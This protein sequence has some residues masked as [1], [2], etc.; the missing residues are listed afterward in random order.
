VGGA[1]SGLSPSRGSAVILREALKMRDAEGFAP[2]QLQ[3]RRIMRRPSIAP[4]LLITAALAA[5]AAY[6]VPRGLE[7]QRTLAIA[8]DPAQLASRALDGKFDAAVATHDV[9]EALAAKDSDLA[10]SY[11]ELADA[12]HVA[13]DPALKQKVDAAVKQAASV[14]QATKSFAYGFVE[15][16]PRDAASLAGTTLGDLFVFGDIRDAVRE[17]SRLAMGEKAD[18]MILGLA[19]VGLAITAGTYVTLGAEAP[20]R[21]GLTLAKAARKTGRLSADLAASVSRMLRGVV[22]WGRLNGA[23]KGVSISDPA[24]AIRAARETVKMRRARSL[25]RLA[26]DVGTIETKA[27]TRAALD[28]LE[29]AQSPREMSRVAKLAEKDGGKTRAVLKVAGRAAIMLTAGAFDLTLWIVGALITLFAFVSSLPASAMQFI[30]ASWPGSSRPS[31]SWCVRHERR[32]RPLPG[33][34]T[35]AQRS[36]ADI[37]QWRR[38]DCLFRSG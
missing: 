2:P 37:L 6:V 16:E 25:V 11:V 31:T 14:Q 26:G 20:A 12:R 3:E 38:R 8:D 21:I 27:G 13:L 32:G 35:T 18:T 17:G 36:H 33:P 19:C 7:A 5:V 10:R 4:V 24:L 1:A 9:N 30:S 22:D 15:G 28:G 29:I 34:G 23:I